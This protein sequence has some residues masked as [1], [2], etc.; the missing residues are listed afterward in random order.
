MDRGRRPGPPGRPVSLR[1]GSGR[2]QGRP[3][4]WQYRA[5]AP[6]R[7]P[8]PAPDEFLLLWAGFAVLLPLTVLILGS[9]LPPL[10][11]PVIVIGAL[12]VGVVA[13]RYWLRRRVARRV[14]TFNAQLPDTIFLLANALRAGNSLP[15]L[16]SC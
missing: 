10:D 8:A 15:R 11:N 1:P 3:R 16:S 7:R 6:G 4:S 9:L 14:D 2:S 5:T 12:V 13:P